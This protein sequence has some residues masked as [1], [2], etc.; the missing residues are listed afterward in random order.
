MKHHT[1]NI[2]FFTRRTVTSLQE[3]L[4]TLEQ[5]NKSLT[6]DS[7]AKNTRV[8]QLEEQVRKLTAEKEQ[9]VST[10]QRKIEVCHLIYRTSGNA[11]FTCRL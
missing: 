3:R 7:A 9:L 10:Y 4:N 5:T 2:I 1:I 8:D 6:E 11:V